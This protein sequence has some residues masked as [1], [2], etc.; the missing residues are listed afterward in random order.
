MS[1][2]TT[3]TPKRSASVGGKIVQY[4][5]M[6]VVLLVSLYPLLWV[7]I[8]SFKKTP[9]GLDLPQEWIFDGYRTIFTKLNIATYFGN[10]FL[11][12]VCS[13]MI[14]VAIVTMSAYICARMRFKCNALITF[15][16][17]S[18]LFI[19]QYA[20]SFP[21]YRLMNQIGLYNTRTGLI[22]VYTGLNI[23]IS[24]FII[25]GYFT[26][27]PKEME[28]AAQI[29]GCGYTGTFLRVMMPLA[30]PGIST[31]LVLAF[32]NNWNEFYFASLLLQSKEKM[33]IPALLGQFTT[34]YAQNLNGMFSAIIVAIVP[35]I[36]VF[37]FSSEL[38][39]KSL[40][41]G[42]VKG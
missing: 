32:L 20:I 26:G 4:V 33:T 12:T 15:M 19:P 10:S 13:T 25:R 31:G 35:T 3:E 38:F 30:K 41:D 16:F 17:A 23:A 5:V 1:A 42:A 36:L 6:A 7:F 2:Q 11:V 21:I 28:E 8:S 34:A 40:T 27:I 37:C 22:L 39:V 14:S 18:T 24:F 9:G 29:D